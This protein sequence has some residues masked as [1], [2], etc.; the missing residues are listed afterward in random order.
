MN[1]WVNYII[2]NFSNASLALM[3]LWM[4]FCTFFLARGLFHGPADHLLFGGRGHHAHAVAVA[5]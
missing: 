5:R 3:P 2:P 4:A 1:G